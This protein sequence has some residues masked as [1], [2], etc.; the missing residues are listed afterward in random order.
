[1]LH[2]Q[3]DRVTKDGVEKNKNMAKSGDSKTV[4][5]IKNIITT[6]NNQ[7]RCKTFAKQQQ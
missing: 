2:H 3:T 1:M 4:S 7:C 5:L 6:N